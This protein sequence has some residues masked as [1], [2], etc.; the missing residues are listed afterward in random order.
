M[1]T[2]EYI[3]RLSAFVAQSEDDSKEFLRAPGMRS[4][5]HRFFYSLVAA[6]VA[7]VLVVASPL[8]EQISSSSTATFWFR[9]CMGAFMGIAVFFL[10]R[11]AAS[12]FSFT[13]RLGRPIRLGTV[14]SIYLAGTMLFSMVC[15]FS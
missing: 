5:W 1:K 15:L 2:G 13:L 4:A 6:A 3:K 7:N 14:F 11:L 9:S 8:G 10:F 12:Y